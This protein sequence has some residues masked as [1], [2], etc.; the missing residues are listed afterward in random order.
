[1]LA[2]QPM[3][4]S[5]SARSP[6]VDLVEKLVTRRKPGRVYIRKGDFEFSA[7]STAG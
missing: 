7:T 5:Y 3:D 1:M 6:I 2:A 4:T